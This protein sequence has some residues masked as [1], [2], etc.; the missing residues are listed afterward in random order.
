MPR[1]PARPSY[2]AAAV[3]CRFY[4]LANL[5]DDEL[6]MLVLDVVAAVRISDVL[7]VWHEIREML[8]RHL[9]RGVDDVP[10]VRRSV[11]WYLARSDEG[12]KLWP[13]GPVGGQH[14]QG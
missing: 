1:K 6:R 10:K 12:R 7:R 14:Y 13:P 5:I 4:D 9:L 2:A 8:L 3:S 11:R